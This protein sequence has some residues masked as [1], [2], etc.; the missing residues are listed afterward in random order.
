MD[1]ISTE[2]NISAQRRRLRL[3]SLFVKASG[4]KYRFLLLDLSD[5]L[6]KRI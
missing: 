4:F 6:H 1:K 5:S 2:N 3:E